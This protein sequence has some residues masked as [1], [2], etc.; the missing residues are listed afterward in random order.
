VGVA[1]EV[2]SGEFEQFGVLKG[3][4]LMD[5]SAGDVHAFA[6]AKFELFNGL[7]F[8]RL[9]DADEET[10]AAEV[11]GLGLELVEVEG[12]SFAPGDFKDL[13]AVQVVV[14]DPHL[15]APSFGLDVDRAARPGGAGRGEGNAM[16]FGV[17]V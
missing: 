16:D 15:A 14:D 17:E 9:L 8:G 2:L 13:A 5:E 6:G 7:S 4:H 11:E 10:T 12:A 1:V 3:F